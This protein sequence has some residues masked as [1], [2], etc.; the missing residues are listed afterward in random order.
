MTY[1]AWYVHVDFGKRLIPPK[2][3]TQIRNL[4]KRRKLDIIY[5]DEYVVYSWWA[6]WMIKENAEKYGGKVHVSRIVI[7]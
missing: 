4:A 7:S 3:F 6:L 2:F 5:E 1:Y